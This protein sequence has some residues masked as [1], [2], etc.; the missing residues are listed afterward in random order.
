MH[1]TALAPVLQ[2]PLSIDA[3][4]TVAPAGMPSFST[5]PVELLMPRFTTCAA[6]R[7]FWPTRAYD[8]PPTDTARSLEAGVPCCVVG[9][10]TIVVFPW[11]QLGSNFPTQVS[12]TTTCCGVPSVPLSV[13]RNCGRPALVFRFRP[14]SAAVPVASSG[15]WL[16]PG[17]AFPD[18]SANVTEPSLYA[19]GAGEV[20]WSEV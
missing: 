19:P 9:G 7:T 14:V 4:T 10:L 18:G 13:I 8:G 11:A 17:I 16:A 1:E 6:K 2:L 15:T 5:T 20:T 3:E 12:L